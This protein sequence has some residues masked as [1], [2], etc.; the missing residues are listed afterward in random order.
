MWRANNVLTPHRLL[1]V[2]YYT[3]WWRKKKS[4]ELWKRGWMIEQHDDDINEWVGST[5]SDMTT[6]NT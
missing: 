1:H 6:L 3:K 5:H 2:G 4:G